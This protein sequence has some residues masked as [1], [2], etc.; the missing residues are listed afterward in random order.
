MMRSL[1][2]SATGMQSQQLTTDVVA[3]NLSNVNTTGFKRSRVDFQDLLYQDMRSPGAATSEAGTIVPVGIQVGLGSKP[4][5]VSKMFSQGNLQSTSNELDVA[6]S[7]GGFYQIALPNGTTAYTR[8]GAFKKD[9]TG[10]IVNSD[11]YPLEPAMVIPSDA[12]E[13]TISS[14][15]SVSVKIG[16]SADLTS[17]GTIQ[18][19][20]FVNSA[21][22][23]SM[24][25]NL[26]GE[27][28]ASGAPTV[29]NP[30]E[31]AAGSLSQ[32]FLEMSNVNMVEEMINL[33]SSQ[34]AYELNSKVIQTSD[35]MLS[36]V[37]SL[38]R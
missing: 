29:S 37:A 38:K 21:G 35:D 20:T 8:D 13:V 7:G 25:G 30:G 22:L 5:A 3:N 11:G 4:V 17:L 9:A 32:G 31:G 34:R 33:I 27:S 14:D 23:T 16:T 1:W 15:G 19:A 24:G 18:L 26:L 28:T 12:T 10:Q 36:Q 2:T 6:I